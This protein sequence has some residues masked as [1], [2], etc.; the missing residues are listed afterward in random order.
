MESRIKKVMSNVL[1]IDIALINNNT[2]PD[3]VENWD[4]LKH[5]NLIIAL[6]EE[7]EFEFDEQ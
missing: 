3:N 5:M 6:E 7:F 2:S 1:N 4:S